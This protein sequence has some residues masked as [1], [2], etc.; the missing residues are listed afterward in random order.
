M[1]R[2]YIVSAVAAV[3]AA[4][5]FGSAYAAKISNIQGLSQAHFSFMQCI[6]PLAG[7]LFGLFGSF[8]VLLGMA[9]LRALGLMS[10]TYF[11]LPTFCAS[12]CWATGHRAVRIGIPALC[13][14]LFIAHPIGYYAAPYTLYWLIPI[15]CAFMHRNNRFLTAISST[16]VAH[17]VGSVVHIYTVNA[18]TPT[19][20]LALI[21][22]VALERL[23]IALGMYVAYGCIVR[24]LY[25]A[26]C[27]LRNGLQQCSTTD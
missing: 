2:R 14:V 7:M 13:M 20:W 26:S 5:L 22:V 16:F 4:V 23:I 8:S 15:A 19:A 24:L 10:F 6:I 21:P 11:G 27:M 3:I 25:L 1:M 17:A 12:L 18:M 9:A